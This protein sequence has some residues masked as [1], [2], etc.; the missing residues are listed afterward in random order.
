MFNSIY[1]SMV[2]WLF[3]AVLLF[4]ATA[5]NTG[6][7]QTAL[8]ESEFGGDP[9]QIIRIAFRKAAFLTK[10][11]KN[12]EA[13]KA[14]LHKLH[15]QFKRSY[16][17]QTEA[18]PMSRFWSEIDQNLIPSADQANNQG[19]ARSFL[20]LSKLY[21]QCCRLPTIE[22][23]TA[24][25]QAGEDFSNVELNAVSPEVIK[26]GVTSP[27]PVRSEQTSIGED[28]STFLIAAAIFAAPVL[29]VLFY[30][31]YRQRPKVV[32]ID[33]KE[34][35]VAKP[36]YLQDEQAK[37]HYNL[38]TIMSALREILFGFG[39]P[40]IQGNQLKFGEHVV[41]GDTDIVDQVR[42]RFGCFATIFMKD[43]RVTTN[44]VLLDGTRAIGTKLDPGYRY[45]V[46]MK[47][48]NTFAGEVELFGQKILALYEPL[49]LD[50][51][52]IGILFIG[53]RM[54]ET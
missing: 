15:D 40:S 31:F 4:F 1:F 6:S 7:A 34:T 36:L 29:I 21:D 16:H 22:S 44:I 20:Q 26:S 45:D 14:D 25:V 24:K 13:Y 54:S 50:N 19:V 27:V 48:K 11:D 10:I 9:I 52:V 32:P 49:V 8:P 2:K 47:D 33:L 18:D 5:L 43:E 42:E 53:T 35:T 28:K 41:N 39:Q 30:M 37:A 12:R 17:V 51:E 23:G 38:D 3:L 46:I